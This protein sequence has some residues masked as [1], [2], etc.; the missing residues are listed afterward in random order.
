MALPFLL[1]LIFQLLLTTT[2]F[3]DNMLAARCFPLCPTLHNKR[4]FDIRYLRAFFII[5][6]GCNVRGLW[7]PVSMNMDG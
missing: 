5:G 3:V 4:S 7:Y 6:I 2:H 1:L